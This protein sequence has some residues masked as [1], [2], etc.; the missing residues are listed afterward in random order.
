MSKLQMRFMMLLAILVL[1]AG[2]VPFA[3]LADGG[4]V[5]ICNPNPQDRLHLRASPS[6]TA[7]SLGK[8]Y[9]GAPIV[10]LEDNGKG[11]IRVR[12]GG[13]AH[14]FSSFFPKL[15]MHAGGETG[16]LT[17][18]MQKKFL[19]QTPV[20]SAMPQYV[21]YK[22]TAVYQQPSRTASSK[23]VEAGT[24]IS[25]MGFSQTWWHILV[26]P[27]GQSAY[28]G[29]I[30]ADTSALSIVSGANPT[31]KAYISNP[32]KN[33]RL[34]LRQTPSKDGKDLGK[35]YNGA[36]GVVLGF[37]E[38][39]AWVKVDMYGRQG[40][41]LRSCLTLEGEVNHA[42]YGI[43]T[44]HVTAK[45]ASLYE[46]PAASSKKKAL[47]QSDA[48]EVLGLIDA[49]WLHVSTGEVTGF[50]KWADTDFPQTGY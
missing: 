46:K 49:T 17:G 15:L 10:A 40:Y 45:N 38:D 11:W 30:P 28:T 24:A 32:D 19:S 18:W 8:Y 9:N 27:A 33:D 5:Y 14:M 42:Y 29:F 21:N 43:P 50:V 44:I 2:T 13:E 12:V 23:T 39:G 16:S 20:Q 1:L 31:V 26:L 22:K 35:Y 7:D 6:T 3:A 47:Q 4:D 41:M 25:L 48:L 34:H 37:S 36:I